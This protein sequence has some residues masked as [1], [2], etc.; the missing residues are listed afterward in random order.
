MEEL[1]QLISQRVGRRLERQGS[2]EPDTVSAWLE[3]GPAEDTDVTPRI[4]GSS[5]AYRFAAGPH[6]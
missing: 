6:R 1:V 2:L 3:L 5:I 4:L